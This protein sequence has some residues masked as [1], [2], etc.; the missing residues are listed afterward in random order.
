M[1]LGGLHKFYRLVIA[2]MPPYSV[3]ISLSVAPV[4]DAFK[5][6]HDSLGERKGK[7]TGYWE[8]S[9]VPYY[10]AGGGVPFVTAIV[11]FSSLPAAASTFTITRQ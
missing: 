2:L 6:T 7:T 11:W 10:L 3:I 4:S 9:I 1:R 8:I 5:R